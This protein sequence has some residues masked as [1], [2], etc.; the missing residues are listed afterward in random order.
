MF[1]CTIAGD[2]DV[3]PCGSDNGGCS[4]LC[5]IAFGGGASTCACPETM[6]LGSDGHTCTCMPG[7]FHCE[8][9]SQCIVDAW[10]C[11]GQDDCSGG[12]DEQDC[13]K[14]VQL[15]LENSVLN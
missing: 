11:D 15:H 7:Y 4:H 10:K 13:S 8:N 6:V 12:E 3:S 9:G 1:F 14:C 2:T 5:L